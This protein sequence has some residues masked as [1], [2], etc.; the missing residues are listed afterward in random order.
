V[1]HTGHYINNLRAALAQF[2]QPAWNRESAAVEALRELVAAHDGFSA[3]Q[4]VGRM[5]A[6]WANAREAL[7]KAKE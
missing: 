2:E 6:A 1:P 7:A 5:P 3:T 4:D